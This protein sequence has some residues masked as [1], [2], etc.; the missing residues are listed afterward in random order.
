MKTFSIPAL[1]IYFSFI[2]PV[3]AEE[4][5]TTIEVEP[6]VITASKIM[7]PIS[8]V[9]SSIAVVSREDIR[10]KQSST[11]DEAVRSL[12]GLIIQTYG[13]VD[14]WANISSRGT[15]ANQSIIMIDGIKINSPYSQMPDAG[16]LLLGH[17]ERVEVVKGSYSALY[18][19]EAIGGVVNII[20]TERPG[21]TY[22]IN[23][24]THKTF[25]SS[26]L[27]SGRYSDATYTLGYERLSTAGFKFSGPFWDNT[28]SGKINVPLGTTSTIQFMTNYWNWK[29]YDYTICC[30][31]DGSGNF[32]FFLD[33]DSHTREDNWLSS[34]S[35][36]HV[37]AGWWDYS[38]KLSH[39]HVTSRINDEA[40]PATSQ[41]PFPLEIDSN[42]RSKRDVFE[43]QHNFYTGEKNITTLGLQYTFEEVRKEEFGNLDSFG[44]GPS[45]QQP[46]IE[47]ERVSRALYFQNL[48]K[49]ERSFT[50]SAGARFEKGPGFN[51]LLVPKISALY[52]LPSTE[53]ELYASYGQGIRAPSLQELYHPVGGNPDLGPEKSKSLEAGFR[54]RMGGG[55][56][57]IE[58]T[59]F[60]LRLEDL[61]DWNNDPTDIT[62]INIGRS[63]IE[64]V[65]ASLHTEITERLHA[66]IGY[67]RLS[68]ENIDTGEELFFRPHYRWTVDARYRAKDRLVFDINTEFVGR[69]F[70]PHDFL[71]GLD[72]KFLSRTIPSYRVV[73]MAVAYNIVKGDPILGSLDF[74]LR[75]N[76]LFGEDYVTLPGFQNYGFTFLA[77]LR[78]IR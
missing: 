65:E 47:A 35:L 34:I 42:I 72:G 64:G 36:T 28:L 13:G 12:S 58:A 25:N 4:V 44:M 49:I 11:L 41:R 10:I 53:T 32:A 57:G 39:Y 17:V 7:E 8:E 56:V 70:N 40:D 1:V 33:R 66:D 55:R 9:P 61:I 43:M 3:F 52:I 30:E 48:F 68:T 20:T 63:R 59:V 46:G 51:S 14:P 38:I 15:D 24:G 16:T 19:S 60:T 76:N 2:T 50:F 67:T 75:L 18:G 45:L 74:T 22:F 6:I 78:L 27:Y 23:G 69:A 21:F 29:K 26:L 31:I 37:P 62:Y 77:G 54:Q 73:N 71:V 5:T